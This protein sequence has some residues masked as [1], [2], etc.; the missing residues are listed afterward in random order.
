MNEGDEPLPSTETRKRRRGSGFRYSSKK[1]LEC[2]RVKMRIAKARIFE[3]A[4]VTKALS[5]PRGLSSG[6]AAGSG[7]P[8][9][10]D[11]VEEHDGESMELSH[12]NVIIDG[13]CP[14]KVRNF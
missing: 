7:G 4:S 2:S 12:G 14:L 9:C 1:D 11:I 6:C 8:H 5:Y 3:L 13:D 10:F